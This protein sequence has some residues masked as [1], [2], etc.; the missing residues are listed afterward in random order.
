MLALE[1]GSALATENLPH[2][3]KCT[4]KAGG[5][6]K[7]AGCTK[8]AKGAEEQR[9]EWEPLASAVPF[10]SAKQTGSGPV[11]LESDSGNEISCTDQKEKL[12]STG[13]KKTLQKCGL[14][15]QRMRIL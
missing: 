11:V 13:P 4:K 1:A 3:G 12:A 15:I 5:K 9:F 7:S 8:L 6:Y 14:G 10:T 2:Y